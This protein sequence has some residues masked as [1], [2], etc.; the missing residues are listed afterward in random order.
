[1]T[2]HPYKH[3]L[4]VFNLYFYFSMNLK[5]LLLA[6]TVVAATHGLSKRDSEEDYGDSENQGDDHGN[7]DGCDHDDG[8]CQIVS[9]PYS[10]GL[11]N[12]NGNIGNANIP[13]NA[14]VNNGNVQVAANML[15]TVITKDAIGQC[16]TIAANWLRAAFHD[17]GTFRNGQFGADGSL[18][19]ELANPANAGITPLTPPPQLGLADSIQLGGVIAV[20]KCG[21]PSIP[22]RSGR[23]NVAPGVQNPV[24]LP[25]P[26]ISVNGLRAFF[27][28]LGMNDVDMAVLT[29]GSHTMGGVDVANSPNLPVFKANPGLQF[30]PFDDTPGIFD[31]NVFVKLQRNPNDCKLPIDCALAQDPQLRPLY[32]QWAN[33][34]NSFFTQYAIS[35]KKMTELTGNANF[36][37]AMILKI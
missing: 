27:A 33:D 32:V 20:T 29:T 25:S 22:F 6:F 26:F 5:Y 8:N 37:A 14:N 7:E 28:G 36:D 12:P 1:L 11:G 18:V 3:R 19:N 4:F 24:N 21:G 31:N 13:G 35:F 2:K 15:S 17:A 30:L 23:A 34:Q 16:N 10:G 9:P